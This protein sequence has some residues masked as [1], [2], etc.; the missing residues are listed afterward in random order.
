MTYAANWSLQ[1]RTKMRTLSQKDATAVRAAVSVMR[2][3][4]P[5]APGIAPVEGTDLEF[6]YE[7]QPR[8]VLGVLFV[9]PRRK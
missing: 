7:V 3:R 5:E 2:G 8:K 4:M 6:G 9:R 1:A